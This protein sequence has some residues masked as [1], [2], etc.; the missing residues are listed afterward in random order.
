MTHVASISVDLYI[1][2]ES[3]QYKLTSI[4]EAMNYL[5]HSAIKSFILESPRCKFFSDTK[6]IDAASRFLFAIRPGK[7]LFSFNRVNES[8]WWN[9][10]QI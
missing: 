5:K 7:G 6:K 2:N 1:K 3:L 10:L 4:G 8:R 9:K